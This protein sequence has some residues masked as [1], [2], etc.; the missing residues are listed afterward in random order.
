MGPREDR[1][2]GLRFE[3]R[4]AV[5]TGAGAGLGAATAR[6]LAQ[7]GANLVVVDIEAM[8][9]QAIAAQLGD[10]GA[11]ALAVEAD[12]S[13]P[14]GARQIEEAATSLGGADILVNN[15][16]KA[17]DGDFL[18]LS[19]GAIARDIAVNLTGP[20]LCA[21]ALLPGMIAKGSGAIC[22]VGSVNA[23]A[24]FGNEAYSAAKAGLVS[25][26]RSLASQYGPLGVR[27]NMVAPGTMRTGIWDQR[28]ERDP[29]LLDRLSRWYPLGRIG[30]PKDVV[31]AIAFL[32]SDEAS[33]V[34][35]AILV[36]DGGLTS[37]Y[38]QMVAD[39]V[40]NNS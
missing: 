33:W 5:V 14:A 20:M 37:G 9:C 16:A 28:L 18:E 27:S 36:V 23:L 32:C 25:F 21:K 12:I 13:D 22:N 7:E 40:G 34:S 30:E 39:I 2:A 17:T 26:T 3:G 35:G 1:R 29:S 8:R 10:I 11:K 38:P 15:A 4:T 24:F 31:G 19:A 6:C